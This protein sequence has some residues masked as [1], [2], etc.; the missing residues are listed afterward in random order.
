MWAEFLKYSERA[1]RILLYGGYFSSLGTNSARPE[2]REFF[3]FIFLGGALR[4]GP[5]F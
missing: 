5:N 4:L 2:L 1:R 3:N